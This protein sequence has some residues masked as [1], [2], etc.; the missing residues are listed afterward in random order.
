MLPATLLRR[1]L[2]TTLAVWLAA[3]AMILRPRRILRVRL[4]LRL[5]LG[6]RSTLRARARLAAATAAAIELVR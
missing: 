1:R 5:A 2:R 4:A 3:T 6:M